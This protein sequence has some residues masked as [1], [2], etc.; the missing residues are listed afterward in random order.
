[1]A[2]Y[3]YTTVPGKIGRLLQK[4]REIGIPQKAQ[5]QWIKSIGF[6]SSN[7][8][9][10][11]GVLKQIGLVDSSGIPTSVWTQFRGAN[12]KEVLGSAIRTGYADLFAVYPDADRRGATELEHV[13]STSTSAGKQVIAKTVAT[14]KALCE[15]A[16]FSDSGENAELNVST[17][18]M[19]QPVHQIP[20]GKAPV[21]SPSGGPSVHIDIQVHIAPESSPEQIDQIFKSMAK[22]L[23]G[24]AND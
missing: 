17:P 11:I 3:T 15:Q 13:F 22:H 23:Y 5:Q 24:K 16:T 12:Y 18:S 6:T 21:T 4:I 9:S 7:D 2:D 10:L 1:M 19:H 8:T 20:Q 14:F